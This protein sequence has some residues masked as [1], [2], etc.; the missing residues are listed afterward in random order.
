M[1][2]EELAR[3]EA[4]EIEQERKQKVDKRWAERETRMRAAEKTTSID[5]RLM[6]F[7]YCPEIMDH[8]VV[9]ASTGAGESRAGAAPGGNFPLDT[10]THWATSNG[11]E[12]L[13]I[14]PSVP[15]NLREPSVLPIFEWGVGPAPGE[16][17]Y[18]SKNPKNASG[19]CVV[20]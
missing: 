17:G 12:K 19:C 8:I 20:S 1:E 16:E 2:A 4:E 18:S 7:L 14:E 10:N 3:R 6:D 11:G 9:G 15:E 13:P 5:G